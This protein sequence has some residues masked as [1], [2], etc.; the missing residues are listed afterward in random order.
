MRVMVTGGAGYIGSVAI[1]RLRQEGHDVVAIDNL[2]RGH[3]SAVPVDVEFHRCDLNDRERTRQIVASTAPDAVLH[4]AAATIVPES[5]ADPAR[6]FETN[7]GGTLN[8]LSAMRAAE[9]SAIVFSST[10]AVYGLP[11]E[12]PITEAAKTCPINPYGHSKL[13]VERILAAYGAAYGL[14]F[15][16]L[17]YFNVGGATAE[18]G[19]DHDPETH[20]IPVALQTLLGRRDRF[21]VFGTDYPTP[22]GTAVRDYVHVVDLVDAHLLALTKIDDA[23]GAINL[24]TREGF[25]VRQIVDGVERVTGRTL[26]VIYQPRR[27]GDPP[28][29]VADSSRA[30]N[31]L[32]WTPKRSTLDE[33]I[34]SAWDWMQRFPDGY[35]DGS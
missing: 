25:S 18:R 14:R 7:V 16:A 29:L 24:G 23:L 22:D 13:M 17:R 28:A 20:V 1:E 31:L 4:F 27:E 30:Q 34:G 21:A 12:Q 26:P 32:G 6:Y 2:W 10:A 35:G 9:A 33:M 8:L 15:A 11:R 5:I 3:R 19:E